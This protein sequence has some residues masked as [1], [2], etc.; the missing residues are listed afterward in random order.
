MLLRGSNHRSPIL[1]LLFVVL[2]HAAALALNSVPICTA[3]Q[4]QRTGAAVASTGGTT[5]V[6]WVDERNTGTGKDIYAQRIDSLGVGLWAHDGI[7][8]CTDS[9]TQGTMTAVSDG[10]GG[11]IVV[12]I[13]GRG[14]FGNRDIY[15]QRVDSAGNCLW[16]TDG[17]PVCDAAEDQTD[18]D[19]AADDNG[20]AIVV[21]EDERLAVTH[22]NIF[23]QRVGP[24]G[25]LSWGA[26]GIAVCDTSINMH[27]KVISDD[28]GGA[29]FVWEDNRSGFDG[30]NY[31]I[32]AQRVNA[33][34]VKQWS[35]DKGVQI[36]DA[37]HGQVEPA[38]APD[39]SGGAII[40]WEDHRPH[41]HSDDI[42]A[43]RVSGS[44]AVLWVADDVPVCTADG[45]QNVFDIV[46]DDAGGAIV[47]WEDQPPLGLF[48]QR[49]GPDGDA[50]WGDGGSAVIDSLDGYTGFTLVADGHGGIIVSWSHRLSDETSY[51]IFAQRLDP[52]SS[53]LWPAEAVTVTN[54]ASSQSSPVLAPTGDGGV[55]LAWN[56]YRNGSTSGFDICTQGLTPEGE[57][58]MSPATDAVVSPCDQAGVI[59]PGRD[60]AERARVF[61]LN[62]ARVRRVEQA[63]TRT[64][65]GS[66]GGRAAMGVYIRDAT[67]GQPRPVVELH[68]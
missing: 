57:L 12:W 66:R 54:A 42:Y 24:D 28:A 30:T 26:D 47:V 50:L 39:G 21:W 45:Y 65:S 53:Q 25:S 33:D 2:A 27:P 29:V 8:V 11:V 59:E 52:S 14:G 55:V 36:T 62:G 44:G 7:A 51:D 68:R 9:A 60:G 61:T 64:G 63:A 49:L 3:P 4:H 13:D 56:D 22:T 19:A 6:V 37:E 43:Q 32:Y 48:A 38:V 1:G 15:A 41:S 5:V 10:A 23:A 16:T 17:I 67:T 20:G 46:H 18:I 58:R 35:P 31:D 34:G 40:I